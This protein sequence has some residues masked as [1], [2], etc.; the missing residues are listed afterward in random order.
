MIKRR[1][2]PVLLIGVCLIAYFGFHAVK[3]RHGLEARSRLITRAA[4][5]E[6]ELAGLVTVRARLE[7]EVALLAESGPDPD[8][9]EEIAR[10]LLGYARPGDLIVLEPR[11]LHSAA[12]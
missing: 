1:R 6:R 5:L 3:G 7:R 12:R 8:Y 10:E 4:T 2:I 9:V 11:E